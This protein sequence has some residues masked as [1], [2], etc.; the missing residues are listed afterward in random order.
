VAPDALYGSRVL[1]TMSKEGG[2]NPIEFHNG[3][4]WPHD[5]SLMAHGLYRYGIETDRIASAMLEA[6]SYFAYRLPEVFAG[7]DRA[8]TTSP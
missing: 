3:T 1:G 7:Y 5:N 6:A 8:D 4:V 2:D